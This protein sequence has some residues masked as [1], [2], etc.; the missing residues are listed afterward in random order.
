[1]ATC[2]GWGGTRSLTPLQL[3]SLVVAHFPDGA[4]AQTGEGIRQT[5]YAVAKAESGGNPWACGDQDLSVGLWQIYTPAHPQYD[6]DSLFLPDYN[7][8]AALD[9]SQGGSNWNPW[10]TWEPTACGGTGT[11]SYQ[12]YLDEAR[13]AIASV[14]PDDGEPI[15]ESP[16]LGLLILGGLMAGAGVALFVNQKQGGRA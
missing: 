7:A 15:V 1:M 16:G 8:Q 11:N 6:Y 14:L 9:I 12:R 10:C 13:Q 3:A 4:V 5:A 2:E